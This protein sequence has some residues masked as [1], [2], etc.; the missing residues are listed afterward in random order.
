M[1]AQFLTPIFV[2]NVTALVVLVI[3][4]GLKMHMKR[5]NDPNERSLMILTGSILAMCVASMARRFDLPPPIPDHVA[6]LGW[7][8]ITV[9][10]W[11][12]IHY[13]LFMRKSGRPTRKSTQPS[14]TSSED[15]QAF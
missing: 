10:A 6:A 8:L 12:R 7:S 15:G 1:L 2:F 4:N 3:L 13:L 14:D 5:W 9:A 11:Y